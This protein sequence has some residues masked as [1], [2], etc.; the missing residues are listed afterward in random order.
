M[1]RRLRPE[2]RRRLHRIR[3]RTANLRHV[4]T[5]TDWDRI[6]GYHRRTLGAS[7]LPLLRLLRLQWRHGASPDDAL[8]LRLLD[9]PDCEIS[10]H[11]TRSRRH[12]FTLATSDPA[13]WVDLHDKL[14][15]AAKYQD[16]LGKT[17]LSGGAA[18][19]ILIEDESAFGTEV[20]VKR[21][22]GQAAIGQSF[23]RADDAR[24]YLD[25]LSPEDLADVVVEPVLQAHSEIARL[26]PGVLHTLR[27]CTVLE[28]ED[29]VHVWPAVL[30]V[31]A[32]VVGA[33]QEQ[34]RSDTL[35]S[36]GIVVAVG[37]DGRV[38]SCGR[39]RDPSL[40]L[41]ER[42]PITNVRFSDVVVPHLT[43][44]RS[45]VTDAALRTPR[46]RSIGWDVAVTED[47]PFLI[48]GNHN[49]GSIVLEIA[50]PGPGWNHLATRH[51]A[52]WVYGGPCRHCTPKWGRSESQRSRSRPRSSLP[53]QIAR[54]PAA[55]LA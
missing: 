13:G 3:R 10:R 18:L 46:V 44:A 36:G 24:A 40:P 5:H 29:V 34:A 1:I 45:L 14:R 26:F 20:V 31:G 21:R 11:L 51:I 39:F 25:A 19:E 54:N 55:P 12:E 38:G 7:R 4:W 41:V 35:A 52:D 50:P 48:E 33:G 30:R 37:P 17:V 15:F 43:A 49:W 8:V 27:I 2:A 23:L 9:R 6:R 22:F 42:H 53:H 47:G 32:G 16:L 28:G